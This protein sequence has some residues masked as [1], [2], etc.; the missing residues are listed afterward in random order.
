MALT[1][2]DPCCSD[3]AKT[4]DGEVDIER[5]RRIA[6]GWAEDCARHLRNEEYYRGLLDACA[7]HLGVEVYTQDDGGVVDEPLRAK[8]P[9]LVKRLAVRERDALLAHE[10]IANILHTRT[11]AAIDVFTEREE[12]RAKW[13]DAHD[14]DHDDG[15][16]AEAAGLL[17]FGAS[18]ERA[19]PPGWAY[20]IQRRHRDDRRRLLVIAA[21]LLLAELDRLDRRERDLPKENP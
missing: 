18:P 10:T 4:L 9:D 14:D 15:A 21:A 2:N 19:D 7:P 8:V 16:L 5:L 1:P 12:Q 17:A 3:I 6:L 20:D 11:Q 13:G